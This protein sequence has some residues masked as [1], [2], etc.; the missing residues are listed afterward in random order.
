M[1][2]RVFT[3]QERK[4][5]DA[6]PAEIA[7]SDL[8]Q[9]FTL[10][11]SDLEFVRRQ[12]GDYNGSVATFRFCLITPRFHDF[13]E[14]PVVDFEALRKDGFRAKPGFF[15]RR[16]PAAGSACATSTASCSS[17]LEPGTCIFPGEPISGIHASPPSMLAG[18]CAGS[19]ACNKGPE[20]SCI[21]FVG[22]KKTRRRSDL[23]RRS[24]WFS[25]KG[26]NCL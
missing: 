10:S 11:G 1:P 23:R 20:R 16:S 19:K 15:Q 12:R 8:I 13:A 5:L 26:G 14:K 6:F 4:H 2:G 17:P 7:E 24:Y 3:E 18:I 25:A 9:Y 21:K 22:P